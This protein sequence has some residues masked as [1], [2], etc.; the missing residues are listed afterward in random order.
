MLLRCNVDFTDMKDDSRRSFCPVKSFYLDRVWFLNYD[1]SID[2]FSMN[3]HE[4]RCDDAMHC[5][6]WVW[7]GCCVWVVC[8]GCGVWG[9]W[10]AGYWLCVG[11]EKKKIREIITTV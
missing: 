8:C 9:V 7:V 1:R 6:T 11:C 4:G 3:C 2:L 5:L 10:G